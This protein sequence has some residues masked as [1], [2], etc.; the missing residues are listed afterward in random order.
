MNTIVIVGIGMA[1]MVAG[2]AWW[3]LK[4]TNPAEAAGVAGHIATFS[5]ELKGEARSIEQSAVAGMH[6]VMA[7]LEALL[8]HPTVVAAVAAMGAWITYGLA[9]FQWSCHTVESHGQKP[10]H[11]E[12]LNRIDVT[13]H[14]VMPFGMK[15]CTA[16]VPSGAAGKVPASIF[17]S[18]PS[19]HARCASAIS[20]STTSHAT[21]PLS[22]CAFTSPMPP[23]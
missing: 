19:S 5:T 20:M 16:G 12:W 22:T 21:L 11:A 6:S 14:G 18:R 10:I 1:A 23:L 2:I 15:S 17:S 13:A 7:R 3:Q 9:A 4:K 8:S